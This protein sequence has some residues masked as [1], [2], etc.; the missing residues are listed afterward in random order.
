MIPSQNPSE[1]LVLNPKKLK[2]PSK[3][4]FSSLNRSILKCTNA[5]N[6]RRW[7]QGRTSLSQCGKPLK[8][9]RICSEKVLSTGRRDPFSKCKWS[10]LRR[11]FIRARLPSWRVQNA[12]G[13]SSMS[14]K[15][16]LLGLK[17][18]NRAGM[19]SKTS[20]ISWST[21]MTLVRVYVLLT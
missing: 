3:I 17:V 21:K 1:C 16:Y 9:L 14:W 13:W 8:G 4:R 5:Q 18:K 19:L 7:L 15:K 12:T 11:G 2:W 6:Y 20:L 10:S